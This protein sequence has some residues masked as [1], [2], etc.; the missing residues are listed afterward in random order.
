MMTLPSLRR[1]NCGGRAW[2]PSRR[3]RLLAV[4]EAMGVA[5]RKITIRD[6]TLAPQTG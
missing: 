2:P 1:G 5:M 6:D 3:V 4:P